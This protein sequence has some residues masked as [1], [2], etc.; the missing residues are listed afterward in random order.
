M[1]GVFAVHK[2]PPG[3][4]WPSDGT[5]IGDHGARTRGHD[6]EGPGVCG[7]G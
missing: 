7:G 2:V 3:A 4:D 1:A 5:P 6:A